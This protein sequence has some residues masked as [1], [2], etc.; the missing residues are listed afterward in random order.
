MSSF[1]SEKVHA[2]GSVPCDMVTEHMQY[3]YTASILGFTRS[4]NPQF[5]LV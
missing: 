5:S 3:A 4:K 2:V 1:A